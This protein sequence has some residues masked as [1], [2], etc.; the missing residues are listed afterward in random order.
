[1]RSAVSYFVNFART[2]AC[3]ETGKLLFLIAVLVITKSTKAQMEPDLTLNYHHKQFTLS[4]PV[5]AARSVKFFPETQNSNAYG[6]D[7]V[8]NKLIY[9]AKPSGC[10]NV[11]VLQYCPHKITHFET[12][13]H[14]MAWEANPPSAIAIPRRYLSGVAYLADFSDLPK[15]PGSLLQASQIT[16]KLEGLV[17]PVS[18]LALKTPASK[19]PEHYNFTNKDFPAL[20]EGAARAIHDYSSGNTRINCLILDLPSIDQEKDEGKLLAHRAFFGLPRTGFTGKIKE[21]RALVE[22]AW[23]SGLDEGYYYITVTP[24]RFQ[25]NAVHTEVI[26]RKMTKIQ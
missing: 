7:D 25:A 12:A 18:I 4:E 8:T 6:L 15:Q 3:S 14:V 10:C 2:L 24:A 19:L 20:S 16:K 26:L 13:A 21:K 9:Q 5:Y 23:F 17:L 22:L 11:N 1:M